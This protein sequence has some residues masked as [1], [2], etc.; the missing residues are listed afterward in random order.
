MQLGEGTSNLAVTASGRQL[1]GHDNCLELSDFQLNRW[2]ASPLAPEL[3]AGLLV[4]ALLSNPGGQRLPVKSEALAQIEADATLSESIRA[5]AREKV[6]TIPR[7]AAELN[8]ASWQ[9]ARLPNQP[10]EKYERALA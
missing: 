7:N 1:I 10:R 3:D 5:A 2:D 9:V 8:T 4:E 6:R